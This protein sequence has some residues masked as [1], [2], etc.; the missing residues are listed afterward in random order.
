M[1]YL[2]TGTIS[3]RFIIFKRRIHYLL[4]E[5]ENS[6]VN[7]FLKTHMEKRS[8]NDWINF[9]MKDLELLEI[10]LQGVIFL[11][12]SCGQRCFR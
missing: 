9:V 12:S 11:A 7:K 2:E 5:S 8:K 6:L 1:L 10:S 3:I 4:N